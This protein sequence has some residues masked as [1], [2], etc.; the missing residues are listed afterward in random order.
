MSLHRA[1]GPPPVERVRP[2]A[3]IADFEARTRSPGIARHDEP[4]PPACAD[5]GAGRA[6]PAICSHRF[7]AGLPKGSIPPIS[8]R[9]RR[10]STNRL[11]RRLPRR[12]SSTELSDDGFA[13]SPL[14]RDRG[15]EVP[16]ERPLLDQPG[17]PLA[18]LRM[19][20]VGRTS[21]FRCGDAKVW[22]RRN[23]AGS[24]EPRPRRELPLKGPCWLARGSSH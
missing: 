12:D 22:N 11:S 14:R 10:C 1:H 7:T 8:K 4:R 20:L 3:M 6:K 13:S 23:P 19:S 18:W 21:P 15:A 2:P 17:D 9:P 16:R 5:S 24:V